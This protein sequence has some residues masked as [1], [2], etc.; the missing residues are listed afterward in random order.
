MKFINSKWQ[1]I[2]DELNHLTGECLNRALEQHEVA[3]EDGE[4]HIDD[5][6]EHID[7]VKYTWVTDVYVPEVGEEHI[8]ELKQLDDDERKAQIGWCPF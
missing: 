8:E 7:G 5:D 2:P 3:L 6:I 1:H 4:Q